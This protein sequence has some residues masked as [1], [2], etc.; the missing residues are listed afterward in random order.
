MF[1]PCLLNSARRAEAK[2]TVYSGVSTSVVALRHDEFK[3]AE[4]MARL[5][6]PATENLDL[7][8]AFQQT[9]QKLLGVVLPVVA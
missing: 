1:A 9:Q 7:M 3:L 2:P 5:E 6:L 8:R 4:G